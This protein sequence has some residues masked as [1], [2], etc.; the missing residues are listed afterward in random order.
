MLMSNMDSTMPFSGRLLANCTC[1][2]KKKMLFCLY[3]LNAMF[4]LIFTIR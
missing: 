3:I 4:E 2:N 1:Y